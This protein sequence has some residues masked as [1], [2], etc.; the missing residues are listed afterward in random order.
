[1]NG[2]TMVQFTDLAWSATIE[3]NDNK[4]KEGKGVSLR[5]KLHHLMVSIEKSTISFPVER[6]GMILHRFIWWHPRIS[7]SG[8]GFCRERLPELKGYTLQKVIC[9]VET[10]L[11]NNS[12][13]ESRL[14]L[15][16][17]NIFGFTQRISRTGA[18]ARLLRAAAGGRSFRIHRAFHRA[19]LCRRYSEDTS[20]SQ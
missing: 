7:F 5:L 4:G 10:E 18:G 1:M 16:R 20:T 19:G 3:A 12:D 17:C 14:F 8:I 15:H 6:S 13:Q 2:I 9:H 11:V